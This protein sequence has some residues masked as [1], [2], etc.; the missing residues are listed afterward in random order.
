MPKSIAAIGEK[1]I[2]GWNSCLVCGGL[3][4]IDWHRDHGHFTDPAVMINLGDA[5]YEEMPDPK[6][7]N[8]KNSYNIKDGQIL[9]LNTK[10]LHKATQVSD[11]RF[12]IT[13]R[14]IRTEFLQPTLF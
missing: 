12:N 14:I 7:P 6:M 4:N 13:F 1:H 10:L 2:P 8:Q 11:V 3:T 9:L 5:L